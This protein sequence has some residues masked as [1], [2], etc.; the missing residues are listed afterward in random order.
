MTIVYFIIILGVIV[1]VH[2]LG[3][4]LVAK[5]FNVYCREFSLG[6]GPAVKQIQGKETIYSIRAIPL[7]GFVAMAGESDVESLD[8]DPSRS[9]KGIH[10]FKR[11]LIMLAGVFANL[12][13][14]FIIFVMIFAYV[15]KVNVA[16]Q[17]VIAG[18]IEDSAA[19]DGGLLADDRIVAITLADGKTIVPKDFYEVINVTQMVSDTM[20]LTVERDTQTLDIEITP[21]YDQAEGR[22]M[23][24]IYLP[25]PE[26]KEIS[27]LQSFYYGWTTLLDSMVNVLFVLSFIIRGI[28][29]QNVSGP[30]GIYEVTAQ[31]AQL[32]F[33]ALVV[34]TAVLSINVGMFNLVPLPVLD[35]GRVLITLVEWIIRRPL[36]AKL[37][38]ALMIVSTL[39]IFGL[40]ILVTLVDIGKLFR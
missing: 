39:L 13:L 30:L 8:G 37:E 35:G 34:L 7:G 12:V 1:F 32:G 15:G 26:V 25:P 9:L 3:H 20:V 22:Y 27:F 19:A 5:A 16:P 18:V 23:I 6:F 33:Q 24:G 21:R 4:L 36:P 38:N 31:Q 29:L 2:E 14:A 28:G 40:I 17:A 11:I 10:P